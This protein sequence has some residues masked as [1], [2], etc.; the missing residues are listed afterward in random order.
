MMKFYTIGC[1]MCDVLESKLNAKGV[2]Y[3]KIESEEAIRDLGFKSAPLLEVDGKIMEFPDAIQFV[4]T[5]S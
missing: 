1:P 2:L 3:E 4:T 5:L